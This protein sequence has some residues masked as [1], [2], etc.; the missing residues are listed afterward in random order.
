M[1]TQI[2]KVLKQGVVIQKKNNELY[3][4]LSPCTLISSKRI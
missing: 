1:A 2:R 4:I 3:P